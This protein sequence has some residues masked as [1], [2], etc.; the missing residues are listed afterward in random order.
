M[1]LSSGRKFWRCEFQLQDFQAEFIDFIQLLFVEAEIKFC[2]ETLSIKDE[3]YGK[4]GL[5]GLIWTFVTIANYIHA[6]NFTLTLPNNYTRDEPEVYL[7]LDN[8][9]KYQY[10]LVNFDNIYQYCD[11][12]HWKL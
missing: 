9:L 12:Y 6:N 3:F 11:I 4:P 10:A 8:N 5:N 1:A 2:Q 7:R